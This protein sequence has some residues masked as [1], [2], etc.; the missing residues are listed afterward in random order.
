MS[1]HP[2]SLD[3]SGFTHPHG[4]SID[5]TRPLARVQ[6]RILDPEN[7][8]ALSYEN[9]KNSKQTYYITP[10]TTLLASVS[11]CTWRTGGRVDVPAIILYQCICAGFDR[12]VSSCLSWL[13]KPYRIRDVSGRDYPRL[14]SDVLMNNTRPLILIVKEI[15]VC[16][17]NTMN[18]IW[19]IEF[20]TDL[21]IHCSDAKTKRRN[22][23]LLTRYLWE[24]L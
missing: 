9:S 15:I 1:A 20:V 4:P 11:I 2:L 21:L 14:I 22:W 16:G 18:Y 5:L 24:Q 13:Q 23:H 3:L 7:D 6:Q 17:A 12:S 8:F 19:R 10:P